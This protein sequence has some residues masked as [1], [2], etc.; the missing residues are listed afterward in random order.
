MK[1]FIKLLL[2]VIFCGNAYAHEHHESMDMMEHDHMHKDGHDVSTKDVEIQLP[3]VQVVNAN[4]E[5]MPIKQVIEKSGKVA[6]LSF[7]YTSCTTVCPATSQ[8]MYQVQ[9]KAISQHIDLS[10]ISVTIDP[11]I[12]TPSVLAGYAKKYHANKD[13]QYLT[14]AYGDILKIEKAFTVYQ[15]DKMNHASS[16]FIRNPKDGIWVR[17]DGLVTSDQLFSIIKKLTNK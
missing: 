8:T 2:L 12:D 16:Y 13:W 5:R 7:I 6:L 3:E 14:G 11:E 15:G 4:S 9:E 17:V 1:F 10:I